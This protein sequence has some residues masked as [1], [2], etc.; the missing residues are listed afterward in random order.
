MLVVDVVGGNKTQR[1]IAENVIYHMLKKLMPRVRNIDIECRLCKMNDDA[2]G[3]AMMTDNRRTYQIDI[4]K[5]LSIKDFVMTVC[6]EMVHV[7]Q[8]FRREMD[9]WNGVTDAR[10][11]RSTVPAETKYYDLPWEKEAYQMQAKL[12]KSCWDKGVF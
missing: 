10:W 4:C 1:K 11:K 3:Y 9:D 12:A 2:V 7:K 5:D 8:Y 6:H